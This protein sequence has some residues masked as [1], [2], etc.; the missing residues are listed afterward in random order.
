MYKPKV[1]QADFDAALQKGRY[2]AHTLLCREQK[3]IDR[4]AR[5]RLREEGV[6]VWT[7]AFWTNNPLRR[8]LEEYYDLFNRSVDVAPFYMAIGCNPQTGQR[9]GVGSE[10]AAPAEDW[11]Q[12]Q[13]T[14]RDPVTGEKFTQDQLAMVALFDKHKRSRLQAVF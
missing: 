10:R 13:A 2:A 1:T 7:R 4:A 3:R 6:R 14:W 5:K 11:G 8:Y 9:W 12:S